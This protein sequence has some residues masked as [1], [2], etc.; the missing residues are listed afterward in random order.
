MNCVDQPFVKAAFAHAHMGLQVHCSGLKF[1]FLRAGKHGV[2]VTGI[3]REV[4]M[5]FQ[6]KLCV[7]LER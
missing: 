5:F 1:L 4:E 2:L 6:K 3:R 7:M